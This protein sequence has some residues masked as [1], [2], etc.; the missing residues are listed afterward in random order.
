MKKI[1]PWL[2]LW[3]G[4]SIGLSIV[5]HSVK[6]SDQ[7]PDPL[8]ELFNRL[9][10]VKL[11]KA[12][13]LLDEMVAMQS[14]HTGAKQTAPKRA[15]SQRLIEVFKVMRNGQLYYQKQGRKLFEFQQQNDGTILA[16]ALDVGTLNE[17]KPGTSRE[18]KATND[19]LGNNKEWHPV[20]KSDYKKIRVNNKLRN[21]LRGLIATLELDSDSP[22][23]RRG[24]VLAMVGKVNADIHTELVA[25]LSKERDDKVKDTMKLAIAVFSISHNKELAAKLDAIGVLENS[26]HPEA[27]N[28]LSKIT[29]N[30]ADEQVESLS[31]EDAKL[32]AAAAAALD[33]IE[34][35]VTFFGFLEQVFFGLSLG[36]VLLLA[37]IGL[38]ITF[39]VM[40]VINMAHGE[41]IMLGAYTTYVIQLMLPNHI[42]IALFLAMPAAF[43]VAGLVGILIERG[44][45]RFLKGRPLETLLATFGISLV[46]Q[47]LVR[48]IFSPLNRQVAS[49]DWLSGSLMINDVFSITYNR[50]YI[51]LFALLIFAGLQLFLKHSNLG[52][53]VR[54]V[55]QNRSMAQAMGI[56]TNRVDAVTFGLGSGVAGIAGVALSQLTNVGPNL[57]QS[58]IIDSFMV[59]VFGGVGN[60]LGT[61]IGGFSLGMANKFLEPM[62]GSVMANIMILVFIII[63][64][65]RRPQGLFPQRGRAAND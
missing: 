4:F 59:V 16:R 35:R 19:G 8:S 14:K 13:S 38:S 42:G 10:E 34:D 53:N 54:A 63:F 61:L 33:T 6:A 21:K 51:L 49:P 56:R 18:D 28:A 3:V 57:G 41:M 26:L 55:T 29:A 24:A 60:L 43:C 36:S 40:G 20:S 1:K 50:L 5:S 62:T 37:A 32:Y 7:P 25:R 17:D 65:Q 22:D 39:G 47:Q 2:L 15:I 52:L 9:T 11:N 27:R 31:V 64:I 58:Y 12:A 48:T 30:I 23:V 46:L 45:I 44:V